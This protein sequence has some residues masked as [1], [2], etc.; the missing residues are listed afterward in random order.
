MSRI[1]R[2]KKIL[3]SSKLILHE[4]FENVHRSRGVESRDDGFYIYFLYVLYNRN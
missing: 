1:G 3:V 4:L 2:N